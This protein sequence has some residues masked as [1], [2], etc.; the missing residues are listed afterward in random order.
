MWGFNND[1]RVW[2]L[3]FLRGLSEREASC[4]VCCTLQ[5]RRWS[6]KETATWKAMTVHSWAQPQG[7]RQTSGCVRA[8]KSEQSGVWYVTSCRSLRYRT[9]HSFTGSLT[10]NLL[11]KRSAERASH[12]VHF[13]R[14]T[15]EIL[16]FLEDDGERFGKIVLFLVEWWTES[17]KH[18]PQ[19]ARFCLVEYFG[20]FCR[21]I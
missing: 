15:G 1:F 5:H 10:R 7:K 21:Q 13:R 14:W 4:A 12:R 6:W 9:L 16:T 18:V 3:R 19:F 2:R 20:C 11:C 17:T 8:S